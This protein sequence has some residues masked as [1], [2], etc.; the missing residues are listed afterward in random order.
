MSAT[1]LVDLKQAYAQVFFG[2]LFEHFVYVFGLYTNYY[3]FKIHTM[4]MLS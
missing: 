2:V 1:V 3:T 4:L